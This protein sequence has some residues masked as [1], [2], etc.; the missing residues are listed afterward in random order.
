MIGRRRARLATAVLAVTLGLAGADAAGASIG[1]ERT[2]GKDVIAGGP[3]AFEICASAGSCKTGVGGPLAGELNQPTGIA[4]GPGN[5]IYVADR[6]NARILKYDRTGTFLRAWGRDV[7]AGNAETG[8]EI[9]VRTG[10]KGGEVGQQGGEFDDVTDLAADANGDVYVVDKQNHRIQKFDANGGFDRAWG[11]DVVA[12]NAEPGFEI[13]TSAPSCKSGVQ[14]ALGGDMYWP[15]GIATAGPS[16]FVADT[17]NQRIQR[18]SLDGGFARAWGKDVVAANAETGS[19]VCTVAA[20][21]KAG[22]SGDLGGELFFPRDV[23]ASITDISRVYVS[24]DDRRVQSFNSNGG[25]LAA[26]GKDV[27]AGNPETGYEICAIAASC[28]QAAP[29]ELGGEFLAPRGMDTDASGNVYVADE[30]DR[31]QE[32]DAGGEFTRAW[33]EDVVA[34][35]AGAGFEVC[36]VAAS[37]RWGTE[38]GPARGGFMD[39]P[40]AV[41]V[42][43]S[44]AAI[45]VA[46]TYNHRVQRFG[47][48]VATAAKCKGKAATHVGTTG[49]DVIV[50]TPGA[51]VIVA[52]AGNDVIRAKGGNDLVCAGGGR[53][54][55]VGGGGDDRLHGQAGADKLK[56]GAGKDLVQGQGGKPDRCNG[57]PGED[58]KNAKGCERLK[59]IP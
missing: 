53:D 33:G 29:G 39:L 21:C 5:V 12:G 36:T 56:G 19:E 13:C 25:F 37:C 38:A 4:V 55:V 44:A 35:N 34:G 49:K 6:V 54:K 32:F 59:K 16:V 27:V 42:T 30:G 51:D 45:F 10:C 22:A 57:G 3:T 15:E 18:F 7:V 14:S 8:Y 17:G 23:A 47:E 41:A 58:K 9:C 52:K 48:T 50:G 43:G 26:W 11:R 2:W 31:I 1:F 28:Q 40:Q 24:G 20:S 46:D